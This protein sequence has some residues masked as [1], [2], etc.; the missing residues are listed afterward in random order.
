VFVA[1]P[2]DKV[3]G[4]TAASGSAWMAGR[5]ARGA[6]PVGAVRVGERPRRGGGWGGVRVVFS[7]WPSA[8]L[9]AIFVVF[10]R[11]LLFLI[12]PPQELPPGCSSATAPCAQLVFVALADP[13]HT[14]TARTLG[15]SSAVCVLLHANE[16]KHPRARER[17][18]LLW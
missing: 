15:C 5:V 7:T 3:L 18:Q 6:W 17:R 9:V 8:A 4:V 13:P 12:L 1:F 11:A 2:F 16:F 14:S 10:V